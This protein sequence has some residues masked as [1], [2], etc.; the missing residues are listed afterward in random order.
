MEVNEQYQVKISNRYAALENFDNNVD[1]SRILGKHKEEYRSLNHGQ[2]GYYDLEQHKKWFVEECS[3]LLI[4][5]NSL[6]CSGCRIQ[7][8]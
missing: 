4:K 7:A 1:A 6:N 8:K 5:G 3:E 2:S